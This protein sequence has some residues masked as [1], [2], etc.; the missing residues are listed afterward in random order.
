[1]DKLEQ[2]LAVAAAIGAGSHVT[3]AAPVFLENGV[4]QQLQ[5]E[6]GI[7]AGQPAALLE[8]QPSPDPQPARLLDEQGLVVCL[9]DPLQVDKHRT[10]AN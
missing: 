4:R 8:V 6:A 9:P 10:S 5:A 7:A 3:G 2:R 1:M